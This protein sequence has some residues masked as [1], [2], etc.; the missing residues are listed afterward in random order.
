MAKKANVRYYKTIQHNYFP[1]QSLTQK[2]KQ[3]GFNFIETQN[4]SVSVNSQQMSEI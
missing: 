3:S 1:E 2:Q 4:L